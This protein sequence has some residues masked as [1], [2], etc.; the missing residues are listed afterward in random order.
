M[1]RIGIDRVQEDRLMTTS[2][3]RVGSGVVAAD[4][5]CSSA[6]VAMSAWLVH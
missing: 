1:V 3:T 5:P 6:V 2:P 4:Y